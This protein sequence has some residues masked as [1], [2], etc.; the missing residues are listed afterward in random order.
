VNVK[1][2]VDAIARQTTVLIAQLSTAACV[3]APLA[4]PGRSGLPILG[5]GSQSFDSRF[6]ETECVDDQVRQAGGSE[7][8]DWNGLGVEWD[9]TRQ[10]WDMHTNGTSHP[11]MNTMLG[12]IAQ[13]NNSTSW[14]KYNYYSLLDAAAN[15]VGGSLNTLWDGTKVDNGIGHPY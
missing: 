15:N 10:F 5:E 13:A 9:W 11:S 14:T 3:R 12:W 4:H 6:I 1:L 7:R 8:S 2:L